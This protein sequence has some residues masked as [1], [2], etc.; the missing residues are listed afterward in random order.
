LEREKE[1]NSD[2]LRDKKNQRNQRSII[3]KEIEGGFIQLETSSVD[4]LPLFFSSSL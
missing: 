3:S 4:V 1:E 2:F